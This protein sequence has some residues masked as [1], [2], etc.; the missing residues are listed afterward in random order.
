MAAEGDNTPAADF[1]SAQAVGEP[2][3]ELVILQPGQG[4]ARVTSNQAPPESFVSK[5]V[6]IV[7]DRDGLVRGVFFSP[8]SLAPGMAAWDGGVQPEADLLAMG[9]GESG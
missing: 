8:G 1:W 5:L 3:P 2:L 7:T 6:V 4:G 9:P